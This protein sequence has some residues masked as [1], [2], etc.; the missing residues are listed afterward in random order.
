MWKGGGGAAANHCAET[1]RQ[2]AVGL[3]QHHGALA[4]A[5]VEVE[6][7]DAEAHLGV[8]H[9]PH[10]VAGPRQRCGTRPPGREE[11]RRR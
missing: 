4:L 6:H 7:A 1:G 11:R 8:A 5:G 9:V 2:E 10:L 3:L